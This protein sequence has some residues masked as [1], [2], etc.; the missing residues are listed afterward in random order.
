MWLCTWE[1]LGFKVDKRMAMV[2]LLMRVLCLVPLACAALVSGQALVLVV[3][4]ALLALRRLCLHH[5]HIQHPPPLLLHM[6]R[7]CLRQLA[8]LRCRLHLARTRGWLRSAA[9]HQWRR[10][11]LRRAFRLL[12][13]SLLLHLP[14]WQPLQCVRIALALNVC[15]PHPPSHLHLLHLCACMH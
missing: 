2:A 3:E 6:L 11:A 12:H 7:W 14:L 13:V 15:P 10:S 5:I 9:Y 4:L 1:R 8:L